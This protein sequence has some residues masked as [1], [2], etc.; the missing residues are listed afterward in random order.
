MKGGI[1]VALAGTAAVVV[2]RIFLP[3]DV[4]EDA[5]DGVKGSLCN[6]NV[7]L[8]GAS[9]VVDVLPRIFCF[10]SMG[11]WPVSRSFFFFLLH[12]RV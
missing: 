6:L 4:A 7:Q 3:V 11:P 12:Y 8:L 9:S 5:H 10:T 1:I 2:V